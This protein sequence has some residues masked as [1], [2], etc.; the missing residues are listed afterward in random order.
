MSVPFTQR[1]DIGHADPAV[2]AT[3][4]AYGTRADI[5]ELAD[6]PDLEH[7]WYRMFDPFVITVD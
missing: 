2:V 4:C 3:K 1:R 7:A 6:M 5:S